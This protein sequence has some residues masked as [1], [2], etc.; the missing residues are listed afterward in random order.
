MFTS[1]SKDCPSENSFQVWKSFC[2]R[3]KFLRALWIVEFSFVETINKIII[4]NLYRDIQWLN[5]KT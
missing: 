5:F 3:A 2:A 4:V 1:Q